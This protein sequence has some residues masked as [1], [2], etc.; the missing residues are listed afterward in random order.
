MLN[1]ISQ[2]NDD[3]DQVLFDNNSDMLYT[4]LGKPHIGLDDE[5]M[6]AVWL[7]ILKYISIMYKR[8]VKFKSG[9]G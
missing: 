8:N 9:I 2:I 3:I 6:M 7:I 5:H 4:I 1:E